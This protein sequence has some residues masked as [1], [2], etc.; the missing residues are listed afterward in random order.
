MNFRYEDLISRGERR[1]G[2]M[3]DPSDLS[4][5]FKPWYGTDVRLKVETP[6][7]DIQTGTVGVTTGWR[8]VFILMARSSDHGSSSLVRLLPTGNSGEFLSIHPADNEPTIIGPKNAAAVSLSI[9]PGFKLGQYEIIDA[10]GA[11]GMAAVL[12]ARDTDLGRIVALKILPPQATRAVTTRSSLN[13]MCVATSTEEMSS[14]WRLVILC[15]RSE[16]QSAGRLKR[17]ARR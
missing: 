10:L 9:G 7:G 4:E 5:Q 15:T 17:S 11:G 12:K 3:F 8:P 6:W 14:S 2:D 13:S 1:H 16:R